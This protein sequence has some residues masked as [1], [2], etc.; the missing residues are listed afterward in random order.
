[1]IFVGE[2]T[3]HNFA[4]F[5]VLPVVL[6]KIHV[7]WKVNF[8]STGK[9]LQTLRVSV[10]LRN[11]RISQHGASSEKTSIFSGTFELWEVYVM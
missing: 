1:M 5:D 3:N 10:C 8:V 6:L 2:K 11:V 7:F 4:R 9:Y